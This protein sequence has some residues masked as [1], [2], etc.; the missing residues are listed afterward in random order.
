M[1]T[2]LDCSISIDGKSMQ[3]DKREHAQERKLQK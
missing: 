2:I 1:N 3:E